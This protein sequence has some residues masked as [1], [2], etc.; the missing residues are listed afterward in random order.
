MF[1]WYRRSASQAGI[2]CLKQPPKP[3]LFMRLLSS[4]CG[5]RKQHQDVHSSWEY[6]DLPGA[7]QNKSNDTKKFSNVH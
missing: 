7:V 1:T 4:D 3:M 6:V 2:S 5:W